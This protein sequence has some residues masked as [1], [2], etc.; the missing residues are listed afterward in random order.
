MSLLDI[1]LALINL[2][3]LEN[4]DNKKKILKKIESYVIL[5]HENLMKGMNLKG[6]LYLIEGFEGYNFGS[7][8]CWRKLDKLLE[9]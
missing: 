8:E 6:L 1:S 9:Q 5:T 3:N 2:D 7:A 4:E